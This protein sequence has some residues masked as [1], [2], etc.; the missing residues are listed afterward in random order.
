MLC[1]GRDDWWNTHLAFSEDGLTWSSGA[2]GAAVATD[3]NVTLADGS[4]R[5]FTNR[6]RPQNFHNESTG[7]PALLFNGVC[8]GLKYTY[9]Y[10]IAQGIVQE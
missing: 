3:P 5:H 1:H 6:E 8:P 7:A 10:T 9:G 4:V 2:S